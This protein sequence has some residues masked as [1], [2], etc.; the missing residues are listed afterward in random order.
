MEPISEYDENPVGYINV[1]D[2][3]TVND[4]M[5]NL[6]RI[7]HVTTYERD[8]VTTHRYRGGGIEVD[9]GE[10]GRIWHTAEENVNNGAASELVE[11][12]FGTSQDIT[13]EFAEEIHGWLTGDAYDGQLVPD[14]GVVMAEQEEEGYGHP[15]SEEE[16]KAHYPGTSFGTGDP[17]YDFE[18]EVESPDM[19]AF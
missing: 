19:P 15:W 18:G 16:Q 4:Q 6:N 14:G 9:I 3:E 7:E 8:G 17:D 2:W 11:F 12:A 13:R 1:D 5:D 10:D